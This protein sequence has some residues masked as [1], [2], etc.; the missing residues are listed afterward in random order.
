MGY[1]AIDVEQSVD[2]AEAQPDVQPSQSVRTYPQNNHH[3]AFFSVALQVPRGDGYQMRLSVVF[4]CTVTSPAVDMGAWSGLDGYFCRFTLFAELPYPTQSMYKATAARPTER[5]RELPEG[6]RE[7]GSWSWSWLHW[8]ALSR[9]VG[10]V[11][12]RNALC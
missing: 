3:H 9:R 11:L 10:A 2:H 6:Q 1:F 8:Q 5:L 7:E 4:L 12:C